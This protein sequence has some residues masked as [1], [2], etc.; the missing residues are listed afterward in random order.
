MSSVASYWA[1]VGIKVD[2]KSLKTVDSYLGK[3]ESKL[4]DRF[5]QSKLSIIPKIDINGFDKHL[6]SVMRNVGKSDKGAY[7]VRVQVS[8]N[9]IQ[10]S[11]QNAVTTPITS[12]VKLKIDKESLASIKTSVEQALKDLSVT[13]RVKEVLTK[14]AERKLS[15]QLEQ[16]NRQ[17]TAPSTQTRTPKQRESSPKVSSGDT[18]TVSQLNTIRRQIARAEAGSSKSPEYW[19]AL[20]KLNTRNQEQLFGILG[21]MKNSKGYNPWNPNPW[22]G[23]NNTVAR[24][25]EFL[26]GKPDK[27][28]LTA[29]NRRMS[30]MMMKSLGSNNG[31]LREMIGEVALGGIGRLGSSTALGRGM[32]IVGNALGGLRGGGVGLAIGAVINGSMAAISGIWS[33][34]GKIVTTPFKMLGGI[35]DTLTS[36]FYRLALTLAPLVGG[37]MLVNKQVQDVTSKDIAIDNT[38]TKFGTTGQ[39]E[40]NWLYNMAMTEGMRYKEMLMPYTSFLNAYAPKQGV[41][42]SREMFHAFSQYGRV[43]GATTE[44]SGRAFYALSQMASKGSIMS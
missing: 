15:K 27:S 2:E 11:L 21:K 28:S 39:A 18:L 14:A 10:K 36:T 26:S 7:R 12:S 1:T 17:T 37:F 9:F 25:A 42:A 34:I 29:A 6:R 24:W 35:V 23:S 40:K 31:G 33:T 8:E 4:K 20:D 30:D 41:G 43:H 13:I 5:N 22:G 32:G 3:I 16:E 19:Q 38:A 44:S